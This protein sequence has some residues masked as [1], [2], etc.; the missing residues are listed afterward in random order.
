MLVAENLFSAVH[1]LS[2]ESGTHD[3]LIDLIINHHADCNAR[4]ELGNTLLHYLVNHRHFY[5]GRRHC[6]DMIKIVLDHGGDVNIRN[7][8]GHTPLLEAL[9][10]KRGDWA[11]YHLAGLLDIVKLLI[12]YGAQVNVQDKCGNAPLHLSIRD[13]IASLQSSAE[14]A[15]D[16]FKRNDILDKDI[17]LNNRHFSFRRF[18][19]ANEVPP[20]LQAAT[21]IPWWNSDD[22]EA[23]IRYQDAIKIIELLLGSGARVNVHTK[24]KVTPLHSAALR[25][26][27]PVTELLINHH[28]DVNA[29]DRYGKT[30]L[31]YAIPREE[32]GCAFP[33][34]S[35]VKALLEHGA[36]VFVTDKD[37]NTPLHKAAYR[38]QKDVVRLLLRHNHPV[39]PTNHYGVT[40]LH[41]AAEKGYS[42]I[43]ELL[44][45]HGAHVNIQN[46]YGWTAY[47]LAEREKRYSYH[48][49][50]NTSYPECREI[51]KQHGADT[52]LGS[53][54]RIDK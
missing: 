11:G 49:G 45:E 22:A 53:R 30:P 51:L 41:R 16:S 32:D 14:W 15:L 8:Q 54:M 20:N 9:N 19:T 31:F 23:I 50:W 28:A 7:K 21:Q 42:E 39:D 6:A 33:V 36:D 2:S 3:K 27:L 52:K 18:A 24:Y 44:V 13:D 46:K 34:S 17:S 47:Q 25:G 1:E 29:Q 35:I 26:S 12:D 4:D 10:T 43:V 48:W 38:G 5:K 40:P 37:G